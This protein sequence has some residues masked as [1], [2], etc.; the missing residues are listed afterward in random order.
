VLQALEGQPGQ[1][2]YLADLVLLAHQGYQASR[3]FLEYLVS[4]GQAEQAEPLVFLAE[5]VF[6]VTRD[7]MDLEQLGQQAQWEWKAY[8][9]LPVF[10]EL[11]HQVQQ[12]FLVF[13]EH[14][15]SLVNLVLVCQASPELLV[16]LE[17]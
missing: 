7:K 1:Q 12:E 4:P 17:H 10:L 5:A 16:S 11:M 9:V 8:L 14:Q 15:V 13:Q 3:V 6:R 2:G